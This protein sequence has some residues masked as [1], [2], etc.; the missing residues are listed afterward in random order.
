MVGVKFQ[1][2]SMCI[3]GVSKGCFLEFF[4]YLKASKRH[5]FVTPGHNMFGRFLVCFKKSSNPQSKNTNRHKQKHTMLKKTT[6]TEH[7]RPFSKNG[8]IGFLDIFSVFFASPPRL[9]AARTLGFFNSARG[10]GSASG[11]SQ[12]LAAKRRTRRR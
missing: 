2:V 4:E 11:S 5:S 8:Q 1:G 3:P 7:T 12:A 9:P 10:L 6:Y